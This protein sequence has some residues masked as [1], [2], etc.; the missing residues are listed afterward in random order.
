MND[1]LSKLYRGCLFSLIQIVTSLFSNIGVCIFKK[2]NLLTN[3]FLNF[4]IFVLETF[5][6]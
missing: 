1:D 5:K 4:P 6:H 3:I 2:S